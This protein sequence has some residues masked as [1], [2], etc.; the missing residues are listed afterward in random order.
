MATIWRPLPRIVQKILSK[1]RAPNDAR[2]AA[3]LRP[4]SLRRGSQIRF[5]ARLSS[6][7]RSTVN[8]HD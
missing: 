6:G 4:Q 3:M 1:V 8:G 7:F 5:T 2:E